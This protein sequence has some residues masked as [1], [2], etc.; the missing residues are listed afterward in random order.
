MNIKKS[1]LL[2]GIWAASGITLLS[3]GESESPDLGHL[4][5]ILVFQVAVIVITARFF[6]IIF[7]RYLKQTRVLGEL[8]S[9]MVIGPYALGMIKL[10][11]IHQSLFPLPD[12]VMPVSPELYGLA[13]IASIVLLFLAGL[14]TDLPTFLRFSHIGT[15]VGLGGVVLSF[16]LGDMIAVLLLPGIDSFMHPT[17]LFLGTLSTATSVGISARI[18][19]EKRKLSS[20]EGV[21]ILAGAVLDDVI[22]IV[23][24]AIVVGIAKISQSGGQ[25]EWGRIGLIALKAFG[26]WIIL[27]VLGILF[28]RKISRGLKWLR[29]NDAM[30]GMALGIAL[31][32]AG[33]AEMAGLAMIIGAYVVGLSLSQTD[34]SNELRERLHGVYQFLVPIFFCVMGMMVN[35]KALSHILLFGLIY[36]A[37]AIVGKM[38]GCGVPALL[39]GFNLRGAFRI[40]AGMLPRGEVT[41]IVAGIGLSSGAI[42]QDMFGVAIMTLLIAS[43]I[44]PPILIKSFEGGSGLRNKKLVR[45]DESG[46]R[47]QLSFPSV[48]IA[49]FIR[50][51]ILNAFQ[52]E[53]FFVHRLDMGSLIYHIKKENIFITFIQKNRGIEL[54]TDPDNKNLASLIVAEEILELKDLLEGIK[55]L[56]SPDGMCEQLVSGLFSEGK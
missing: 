28:A 6:G 54:S 48:H 26:F 49:D 4:M 25:V 14:E 45:E 53:D 19:S 50:M 47:I 12:T 41:L 33:M 18:L 32:F 20:P 16:F 1:I 38:V 5:T 15:A 21:T 55:D 29:S 51:R 17:A 37:C 35:F 23:I 27:T 24:L 44:A 34:M 56:D 46:C 7:E 9:G 36:T 40:G 31:F 8:I 22:G 11:L 43:V 13:V 42:G 10:P 2:F 52:D 3:A 39:A 30:A